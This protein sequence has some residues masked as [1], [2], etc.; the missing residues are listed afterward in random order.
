MN[1]IFYYFTF[2]LL[3][4][5]TVSCSENS[6][7]VIYSTN[8]E[9]SIPEEPD[10]N[11]SGCSIIGLWGGTFYSEK[12]CY[13]TSNYE[14]EIIS[15]DSKTKNVVAH[16]KMVHPD[17]PSTVWFSEH[18][19]ARYKC[20]GTF[21]NDRLVINTGIAYINLRN[22]QCEFCD[23]NK[24]EFKI[25]DCKKLEGRLISSKCEFLNTG[26]SSINLEKK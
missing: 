3:Y 8:I 12:S 25:K 16:L 2:A 17:D 11:N 5:I 23:Y 24:H 1:R 22:S 15:Y 9:G 21:E 19:E 6:L 7:E 4:L 10:N 26:K 20:I 13:T 18:V 14:L